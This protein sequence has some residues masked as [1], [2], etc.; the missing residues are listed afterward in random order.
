[1]TTSNTED[2]RSKQL[3]ATDTELSAGPADRPSST[4]IA[5]TL[6]VGIFVAVAGAW[7]AANLADRFR[8]IE[9]VEH[10]LHFRGTNLEIGRATQNAAVAYALVGAILSLILGVTAGSFLGRFSIPRVLAAGLAGIVLG[11]SFGAASSY[12]LTPIYFQRSD[13]GLKT[14]RK[15]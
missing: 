7:I 9:N 12:G 10:G 14:G 1:M 4:A 5:R 8:I 6:I 11:A 13:S 3:A 15:T 2:E